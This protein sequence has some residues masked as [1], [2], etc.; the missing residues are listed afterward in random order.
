[1]DVDVYDYDKSLFYR[2]LESPK[3]KTKYEF[4][5]EKKG[6]IVCPLE[7]N[8]SYLN[9]FKKNSTDFNANDSNNNNNYNNRSINFDFIDLHLYL[10]SPFYKNHYIPL[11]SLTNLHNQNTNSNIF[12]NNY[13]SILLDH[14]Q[15]IYL[16]FNE[17]EE[18]NDFILMNQQNQICKYIKLLS[19][20]KNYTDAN[21]LYKILIVNKPVYF[22]PLI[23]KASKKTKSSHLNS[24]VKSLN[25]IN[26]EPDEENFENDL[27]DSYIEDSTDIDISNLYNTPKKNTNTKEIHSSSTTKFNNLNEINGYGKSIDFLHDYVGLISKSDYLKSN[28]DDDYIFHA[29]SHYKNLKRSYLGQDLLNELD[30]FR[31]TYIILYTHLDDCAKQVKNIYD[32]YIELFLKSIKYSVKNGVFVVSN[33]SLVELMIS[34][35]CENA[36]N[37]YIYPKLW[38]AILKM[39]KE[40]DE[41]IFL[42]SIQLVNHL[43]L[44][45]ERFDSIE[46]CSN[47]FQI[48]RRYFMI[49]YST[50]LIEI[51]RL[52][53]LNNPFEKLQCIKNTIDLLNNELTISMLASMT[54]SKSQLEASV[55]TSDLL[56]PLI[57]FIL[58]KSDI[59]CLQ[60]IMYFIETFGFCA[61]PSDHSNSCSS[62]VIT[63]LI[64]FLTTFKAAIQFILTSNNFI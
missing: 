19:I 8:L 52:S 9:K 40:Q 60:S 59:N 26:S 42:K 30:L 14:S 29:N 34:I 13:Q 27:N 31:K 28:E 18:Q 64:Y 39:N 54:E 25:S 46:S 15:N 1:M 16:I 36:I 45:D 58:I 41:M 38:P 43:K 44:N 37:G 32:K 47:Y 33:D 61:Q 35:C 20:Q 21:N 2:L 62:S 3:Y 55:I 53:M 5:Q 6:V 48:D 24:N 11:S 4:V 51:K 17:D 56:I 7:F 49:N 12:N 63:E 57:A 23:N 50:I 22:R 10:P